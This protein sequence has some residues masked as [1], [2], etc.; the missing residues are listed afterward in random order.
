MNLTKKLKNYLF[1]QRFITES[2]KVHAKQLLE[3][4]NIKERKAVM[5][6][7]NRLVVREEFYEQLDRIIQEFDDDIKLYELQVEKSVESMLSRS[8]LQCLYLQ[9]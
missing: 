7:L 1:V 4:M 9:T 6:Y 8:D 3:K 5:K 2:E